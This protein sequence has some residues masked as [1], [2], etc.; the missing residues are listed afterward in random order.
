M[1]G[2][3]GASVEL[4]VRASAYGAH[5]RTAVLGVRSRLGDRARLDLRLAVD[6]GSPRVRRAGGRL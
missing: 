2:L 3:L 4:V 1:L 5:D 6:S